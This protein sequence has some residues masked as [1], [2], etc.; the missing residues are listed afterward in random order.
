RFEITDPA[1]DDGLPPVPGGAG[2]PGQAGVHLAPP[3]GDG[4]RWDDQ[5]LQVPAGK[6]EGDL[7]HHRPPGGP[8]A[9]VP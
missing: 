1:G 5:S 8:Q 6:A 7:F 2:L 4:L 3:G 9:G